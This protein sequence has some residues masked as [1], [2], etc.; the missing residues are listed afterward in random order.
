MRILIGSLQV[1]FL[2][3]LVRRIIFLLIATYYGEALAFSWV[4]VLVIILLFVGGFVSLE[5]LFIESEK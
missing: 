5:R 2:S 4:F 1:G 3:H